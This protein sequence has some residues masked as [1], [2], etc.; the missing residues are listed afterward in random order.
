M[1]ISTLED[2]PL[3]SQLSSFDLIPSKQFDLREIDLGNGKFTISTDYV[4][5]SSIY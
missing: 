1:V 4:V 5:K 3:A 2:S